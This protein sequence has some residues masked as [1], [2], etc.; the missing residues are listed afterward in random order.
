MHDTAYRIGGLV[1]DA[2][3]PTTKCRILDVGALNVNGTLRDHCPRNAE[4]VG[5]DFEAGDGVDVVVT[6]LDD[7]GV[8]DGHFDLVMASSAFEHDQAFWLTF[9]QMCRKAKDGG[10]VY[11]NAPSNG[12]VHRYPMDCWRFYPDAGL[13]LQAWARHEG[14]AVEMVE[15]FVAERE[16]DGWNDFCAVFRVG[17]SKKELNRDFVYN[18]IN[19][20]NALNWRTCVTTNP[21]E[22]PE[23]VRLLHRSRDDGH[24][25]RVERDALREKLDAVTSEL[26]SLV[27]RSNAAKS[28]VDLLRDER[29]DLVAD[30]DALRK[31]LDVV[32]SE[33]GSVVERSN[34]AMSEVGLLCDERAALLRKIDELVQATE[35][36]EE[37]RLN[38]IESEVE[39]HKMALADLRAQHEQAVSDL[40]K[41]V[42]VQ[43]TFAA[44]RSTEVEQLKRDLDGRLLLEQRLQERFR[45]IA[46]LTRILQERDV[47]IDREVARTEWLRQVLSTLTRGLSTSP[48]SR[49]LSILPAFIR[50]KHQKSALKAANLFDA[51]IY[52]QDHPDV[53]ASSMD[54]LRH[55][56]EHGIRE[57]RTIKR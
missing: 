26:G 24:I 17:V 41:R 31:E 51:D 50:Q 27:E 2:Y 5:L 48:K 10:H 21:T 53:A 47:A 34:A 28:E 30:R 44:E 45:E 55:Y 52:A 49:L 7:W 20:T 54:P 32:T 16:A 3:L 56:I 25:I 13:A 15:S 8:P 23:D 33:L 14:S 6:G 9:L 40:L 11:V 39:V 12:T 36:R 19:A 38:E 57:G 35:E 29:A 1:M 4:Y 46:A 43:T 22:L 18:K 37:S 42:D